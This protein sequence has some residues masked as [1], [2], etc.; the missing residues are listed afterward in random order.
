M[1]EDIKSKIQNY[2]T[3]PFDSRFPNQNQTRYCWQNYLDFHHCEKAM[4][5]RGGDASVCEWY[6]RVYKSLCPAS[7][8]NSWD[9]HIAEDTFPGKI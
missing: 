5:D 3:A 2:R 9:D 7:W 6:K 4:N 1:S 8:V